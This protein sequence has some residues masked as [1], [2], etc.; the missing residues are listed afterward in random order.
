MP[1]KSLT[2]DFYHLITRLRKRILRR[3]LG[4]P[5]VE[6]NND[7]DCA[8][9]GTSISPI[10]SLDVMIAVRH[11]RWKIPIFLFSQL[12]VGIT[13]IYCLCTEATIPGCILINY[14]NTLALATFPF[15]IVGRIYHFIDKILAQVF[16]LM[17]SSRQADE[18][19]IPINIDPC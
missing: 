18:Q 4:Q 13:S 17:T 3:R 1:I 19:A 7:P 12:V 14:A 11:G 6:Y 5:E 2:D 8:L 16:E 9:L 15:A 10:T